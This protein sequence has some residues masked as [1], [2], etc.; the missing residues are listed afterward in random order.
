MKGWISLHRKILG[1]PVLSHSRVYSRF[2]AFL[3]LLLNANHKDADVVV[4]VKLYKVKK[5]E[6]I[7]SQMKL[8]KKFK[9]G[10]TKLRNFLKLLQEADMIKVKTE[11]NLTYVSISNY[12]TY[13]DNQIGSKPL[14]T[15]KQTGSNLEA[16]TNNNVNNDN[17]DNNVNKRK[18]K[19]TNKVLAEVLKHKPMI[20]PSIIEAFTDYWTEMNRS[21]TKMKF[22]LQQTFEISRRLKTWINNDFGSDKKNTTKKKQ[23]K[24]SST[25]KHYV[26]YCGN[27]ECKDYGKSNFYDIWKV[28][29][30]LEETKC[31]GTELLAERDGIQIQD[32]NA[33]A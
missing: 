8:C 4:G 12:V 15:H 18:E 32:I 5:G 10:N 11:K 20:E 30:G 1:N 33:E 19:F 22:E 27:P 29:K 2:E 31:C 6:M 25:Y 13:Q 14:A 7:T 17:N 9:W 21:R 16:N 26:G 24:Y 3:Y 23:F 28:D